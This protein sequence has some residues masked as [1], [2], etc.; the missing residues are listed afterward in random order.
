MTPRQ[1][2]IGLREAKT[3]QKAIAERIGVSEMAVS[4]IIH[5]KSQSRRIME[6]IA[7]TLG[8]PIQ[9]VFPE[10]FIDPEAETQQAA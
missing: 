1:I 4:L 8:K 3:T 10:Y 6:A 5:R 2:Q 9:E 7:A